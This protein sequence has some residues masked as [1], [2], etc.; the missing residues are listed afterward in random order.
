MAIK[1]YSFNYD[2]YGAEAKFTVDTE[3]FTDEHA[4]AT[5][6]F[7]TWDYDK[8][9]DPIDEVMK[10]YAMESIKIATFNNY[11]TMGVIDEFEDNEGYARV[12]G[13]VGLTLVSVEKYEF[14]PES[15][16]MEVKEA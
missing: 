7:F 8:D 11:N 14:D 6:E 1:T 16:Y 9:A 2:L 4:K 12:D 3:K 5:L 15:L 13:S 10:K